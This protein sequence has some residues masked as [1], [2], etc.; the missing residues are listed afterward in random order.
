MTEHTTRRPKV[1]AIVAAYNEGPRL[2]R[3]MEV[4]SSYPRFDKVVIVDD[5]STDDTWLQAMM[6]RGRSTDAEARKIIV[7]TGPNRGKGG[8]MQLGVELSDPDVIFFCDA[9]IIGLTHDIID[10]TLD[11]VLVG[12]K[13]MMVAMR[14]RSLYAHL[15]FTIEMAAKLGGERALTRD[16][17]DSVPPRFKKSYMIETALNY[18]A[19]RSL[20]FGFK[21][22]PGLSQVVKE[23]KRGFLRGIAQRIGMI[24]DVV[25]AHL[26]LRLF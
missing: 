12:G 23:Q 13:E 8:A 16:L 4:L 26:M 19:G 5:G 17:W 9:D 21:I 7:H 20:G 10:Q 1:V 2:A 25:V 11:P 14:G 22:M 18:T 6:Q 24:L 3:V 15:P